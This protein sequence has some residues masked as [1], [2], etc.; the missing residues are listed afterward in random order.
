MLQFVYEHKIENTMSL[1]KPVLK[2]NQQYLLL[3]HNCVEQLNVID[4]HKNSLEKNSSLLSILNKCLTA[5]GR[6]LC[7]ERFLSYT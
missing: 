2:Q 6:R 1:K 5:V 4:N 7:K 3:S